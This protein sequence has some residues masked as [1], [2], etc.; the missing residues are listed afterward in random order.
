MARARV[1]S[2]VT[3][4]CLLTVDKT[5]RRADKIY[6][7]GFVLFRNKVETLGAVEFAIR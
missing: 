1:Q 4:N 3:V 2:R 6:V 5:A 7:A